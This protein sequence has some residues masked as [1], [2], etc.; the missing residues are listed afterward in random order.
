MQIIPLGNLEKNHENIIIVST[1]LFYKKKLK[2]V[3]YECK[4]V[5]VLKV[6]YLKPCLWLT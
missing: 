1:F 5:D 6:I 2:S 4:N 3:S